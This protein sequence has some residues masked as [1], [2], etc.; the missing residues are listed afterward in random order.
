MEKEKMRENINQMRERH[1]QEIEE[2]QKNCKHKKLS[3]WI[4]E[5]WAIAH[6]TGNIVR[7]CEFCGKIIKRKQMTREFIKLKEKKFNMKGAKK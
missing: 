1:K 3:A 2:L 4:E 7:V 6:S 5:Y